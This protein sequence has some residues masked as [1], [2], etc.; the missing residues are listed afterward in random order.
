MPRDPVNAITD[1]LRTDDLMKD[2]DMWNSLSTDERHEL[3]RQGM[4]AA[5]NKIAANLTVDEILTLRTHPD[6]AFKKL[7]EMF[8]ACMLAGSPIKGIEQVTNE[9]ANVCSKKFGDR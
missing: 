3:L 6:P 1:M 4:W 2:I 8:Q 5:Y 7:R 9:L